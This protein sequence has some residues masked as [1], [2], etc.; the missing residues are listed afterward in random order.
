MIKYK[1][2][3]TGK[4]VVIE[5]NYLNCNGILPIIE[6][7]Y[8]NSNEWVKTFPIDETNI[9]EIA[10]TFMEEHCKGVGSTY[11]EEYKLGVFKGVAAYIRGEINF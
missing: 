10:R 9:T 3:V 7:L 2:K 5:D 11:T 4:E 8:G 1:S 6:A